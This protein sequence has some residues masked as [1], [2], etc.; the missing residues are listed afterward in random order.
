MAKGYVK[1]GVN[2]ALSRENLSSGVCE[3]HRGRPADAQSDQRLCY[4]LL[5]KYHM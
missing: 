5:G 1:S 2:W 4:S 3:H